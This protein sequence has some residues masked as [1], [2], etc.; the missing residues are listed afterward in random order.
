M[1][2]AFQL[3]ELDG[4]VALVTFDLPNQKVN[5][6]ARTVLEELAELV[7]T[8]AGR[9]DLTGLLL[10]SGKPGQFIAGADLAPP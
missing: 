4:P 6:L 10:K 8:L 1:P 9:S 5:T 3:Q 7:T 2:S